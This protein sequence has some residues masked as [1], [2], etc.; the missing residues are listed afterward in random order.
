M[1]IKYPLKILAISQDFSK[2]NPSGGA[3]LRILNQLSDNHNVLCIGGSDRPFEMKNNIDYIRS[4][5]I[6][7]LGT[8]I[9]YL[10][11]HVSHY[12]VCVWLIK[13][14]RRQFDVIQTID[15]ESFIGS[16][17]TF[18]FCDAAYIRL[19]REKNLYKSDSLIGFLV[20][21]Q[22]K[23]IYHLRAYVEA[24]NCRADHVKCIIAVSKGL[25]D[26]IERFYKPR[27]KPV[28]IPNI[29]P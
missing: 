20:S 14:K 10:T 21:L 6:S 25:S 1:N 26:E 2:R 23:I 24:R 15:G 9:S 27:V 11:F 5:R 7:K 4:F 16:V 19:A 18:H 13:F 8:L 17:V 22:A 29:L 12:I 28:I 3:L